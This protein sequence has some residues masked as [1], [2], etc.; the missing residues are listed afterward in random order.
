MQNAGKS[1][2][3]GYGQNP[4]ELT[5]EPKCLPVLLSKEYKTALRTQAFGVPGWLSELN[6]QLQLRS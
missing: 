5:A 3:T 2:W 6:V 4:G 1:V